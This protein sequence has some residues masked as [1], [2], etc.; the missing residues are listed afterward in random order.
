MEKEYEKSKEIAKEY[1][2]IEEKRELGSL[3]INTTAMWQSIEKANEIIRQSEYER[4]LNG[5]IDPRD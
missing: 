4:Y 3:A 5:V 2:G 1:L